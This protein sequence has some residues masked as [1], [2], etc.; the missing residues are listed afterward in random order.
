M[1]EAI[2]GSSMA[3]LQSFPRFPASLS[4]RGDGVLLRVP[5]MRDHAEWSELRHE[6]QAFLKPWEPSW[7]TDDL[8]RAAFRRRLRRYAREMSGDT[9]YPFFIYRLEDGVLT[10]GCTLSNISRGVQQYGTLGYWSGKRFTGQGLMTA[11]VRTLLPYAF[12][13]LGLHRVQ[14]ACLPENEASKAVLRK[15]GFEEEGIARGYLR[16][17]GAWRDHLLFAV[18]ASDVRT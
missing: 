12:D 15:T 7:P 4:I 17:N 18:L 5:E 16:I 3:L 13:E 1:I 9:A 14:A 10:G 2:S 11:A 8:T 6:S